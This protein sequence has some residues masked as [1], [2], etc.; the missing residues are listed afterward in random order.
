MS[1]YLRDGWNHEFI[2]SNISIPSIGS[3]LSFYTKSQISLK[4][5]LALNVRYDPENHN[6]S[7]WSGDLHITKPVGWEWVFSLS[8]Y[9]G[10]RKEDNL[11]WGLRANIFSF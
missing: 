10:S 11:S 8:K 9:Q 1:L 7:Y 4:T 3:N 6:F 5:A 2:I